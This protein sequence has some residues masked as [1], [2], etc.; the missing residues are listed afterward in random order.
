MRSGNW[1]ICW[2]RS[3]QKWELYNIDED[4]TEMNDLAATQP[5]KVKSMS[6]AWQKWAQ[7]SGIKQKKRKKK[8]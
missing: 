2:E 5:E 6:L 1:K 4:R 3:K 8:K 7:A